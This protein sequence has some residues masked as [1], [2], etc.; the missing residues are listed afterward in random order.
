MSKPKKVTKSKPKAKPEMATTDRELS[1]R[2]IGGLKK[3]DLSGPESVL[4]IRCLGAIGDLRP[5]P[6]VARAVAE[7]IA[8]IANH[9]DHWGRRTNIDGTLAYTDPAAA[10][11]ASS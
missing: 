2:V 6:K 5:G 10:V 4:T 7:S 8:D 1:S 9:F 3:Y 11:R